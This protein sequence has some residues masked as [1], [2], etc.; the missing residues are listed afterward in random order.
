MNNSL[1]VLDFLERG[2]DDPTEYLHAQFLVHSLDHMTC[3]WGWNHKL[4][5]VAAVHYRRLATLPVSKE[6]LRVQLQ[7]GAN[8]LAGLDSDFSLFG[9]MFESAPDI[10]FWGLHFEGFNSLV[11]ERYAVGFEHHFRHLK[12]GII[13]LD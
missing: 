5:G 8:H 1:V 10:F 4:Y 11:L 2:G 3:L 12:P 13:H 6:V 9:N 7:V